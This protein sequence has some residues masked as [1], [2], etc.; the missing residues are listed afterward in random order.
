LK[1]VPSTERM[2]PQSPGASS[3]VKVR[4]SAPLQQSPGTVLD[5]DVVDEVEVV[6]D[7]V[8]PGSVDEVVAPGTVDDDV[9]DVE[10]VEEVEV[11]GV[12]AVVEVVPPGQTAGAGARV[13][14]KRPGWLRRTV[15]PNCAQ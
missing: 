3:V 7:V 12:G 6:E 14:W 9:D 11:V 5:V 2:S 8:A 15:P 1:T 4:N 13:A 10:L